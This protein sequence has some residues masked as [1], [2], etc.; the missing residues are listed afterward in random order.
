M[1]TE[2]TTETSL[3]TFRVGYVVT[4]EEYYE[5][6]AASEE[7]A[8]DKAFIEGAFVEQGAT[9]DVEDFELEE[10]DA[11]SQPDADEVLKNAGAALLAALQAPALDAAHDKLSAL[12][13]DDDAGNDDIRDA[14]IDLCTA[15]NAHHSQRATARM[16][17]EAETENPEG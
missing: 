16:P 8:K 10:I 2:P 7:V 15:L 6:E 12:L 1:T 14:A 3:R 9:T 13:E 4:R 11:F 17:F 5:I